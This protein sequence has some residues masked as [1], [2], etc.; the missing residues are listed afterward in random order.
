MKNK[1]RLVTA[2]EPGDTVK[3]AIVVVGIISIFSGYLILLR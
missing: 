3:L 1:H 2:D